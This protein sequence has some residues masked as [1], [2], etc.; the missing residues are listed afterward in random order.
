MKRNPVLLFGLP[1]IALAIFFL[2]CTSQPPAAKGSSTAVEEAALKPKADVP[3]SSWHVQDPE[4]NPID[5]A[6]TQFL[7]VGSHEGQT[8]SHYISGLGSIPFFKPDASIVL[9]FRDGRL[10]GSPHIGAR[11][12]VEGFVGSDGSEVRVR[13]D[14]EKPAHEN[15]SASDGHKALFPYGREKPFLNKLLGHQKLAFEFSLYEE[16]ARV[17]TFDLAGLEGEMK[18]AGLKP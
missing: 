7:S 2:G 6:K 11:I 8:D 12:D 10:V 17:V 4:V 16:A 9:T 1:P 3:K 18:T 14:D 13:F 15:W 5:G